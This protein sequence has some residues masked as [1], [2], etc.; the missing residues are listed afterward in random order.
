MIRTQ[1]TVSVSVCCVLFT[2]DRVSGADDA[3]GRDGVGHV[4]HE[5]R[6]LVERERGAEVGSR[7][8]GRHVADATRFDGQHSIERIERHGAGG[9]T[10]EI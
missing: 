7:V 10:G 1:V 5:R 9:L 4:V 2:G 8:L 3:G 6:G